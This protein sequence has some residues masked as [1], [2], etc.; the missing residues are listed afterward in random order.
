MKNFALVTLLIL[1][2]NLYAG[3]FSFAA[4]VASISSAMNNSQRNYIK[5]SELKKVNSYLWKMVENKKFEPG[6]ELLAESLLES[7]NLNYLDTAAQAYFYNGEKEKAI[8]IYETRILPTARALQPDLEKYYKTMTGLPQAQQ[9]DYNK[10]YQVYK[11]H[12]EN[13]I[14]IDDNSL[15]IQ[16]LLSAILI[17]LVIN[18]LINIGLISIK[19]G[20]KKIDVDLE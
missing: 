20:K 13:A 1:S 2:T 10:V 19:I 16:L 11:D 6:Y 12:K 3:W 8:E 17:V 9:I 7:N 5:P 14:A 4:D 18:L 15:S